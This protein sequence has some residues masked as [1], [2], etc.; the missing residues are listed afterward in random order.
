[1]EIVREELLGSS[2]ETYRLR[3]D[4]VEEAGRVALPPGARAGGPADA[5][6]RLILL[7][8]HRAAACV[9]GLNIYTWA[10]RPTG[11]SGS[12]VVSHPR[13]LCRLPADQSPGADCSAATRS[14]GRG[15]S[16]HAEGVEDSAAA[17]DARQSSATRNEQAAAATPLGLNAGAPEEVAKTAT[18]SDQQIPRGVQSERPTTAAVSLGR[19][20][21]LID[22]EAKI[23]IP[24]QQIT[25]G[26]HAERSEHAAA[27]TSLDRNAGGT[28]EVARTAASSDQQMSGVRAE[29]SAQAA[30]ATSLDR[31]AG[32]AGVVATTETSSDR[33]ATRIQAG[34]SELDASRGPATITPVEDDPR[35]LI[36]C[37]SAGAAYAVLVP[38]APETEGLGTVLPLPGTPPAGSGSTPRRCSVLAARRSGNVVTVALGT[39]QAHVA[40]P[41][42]EENPAAKKRRVAAPAGSAMVAFAFRVDGLDTV[43]TPDAKGATFDCGIPEGRNVTAP[44]E[45]G[46]TPF[47]FDVP[48][49]KNVT[50]AVQ[51]VAA[52]S[53]HSG[54]NDARA[55]I[56]AMRRVVAAGDLLRSNPDG[57]RA[58]CPVAASPS[59]PPA[60]DAAGPNRGHS[61][62]CG[63]AADVVVAAG[64]LSLDSSLP[65]RAAVIRYASHASEV[66][67]VYTLAPTEAVQDAAEEDSSRMDLDDDELPAA[68]RKQRLPAAAAAV[69][70]NREPALQLRR[71]SWH[72]AVGVW[73]P[74]GVVETGSL[75]PVDYNRASGVFAMGFDVDF[76]LCVLRD[77]AGKPSRGNTAG[78]PPPKSDASKDPVGQRQPGDRETS[79]ASDA[80]KD[81]LR[82]RQPG[83]LETSL[84]SDTS[85]G[86]LRQ[87]Q[88]G[89]HD[90]PP[91]SD[92]SKDP[93]GR[94]PGPGHL[95]TPTETAASKFRRAPGDLATPPASDASEGSL[96]RQPGPGD[97]EAPPE[98][99]AS[100]D[101]LRQRTPGDL[102][103]PPES[104]GCAA[105]AHVAHREGMRLL[106]NTRPKMVA[107][108]FSLPL[109]RYTFLVE[110]EQFSVYA[111]ATELSAV[112]NVAT[113]ALPAPIHGLV[114]VESDEASGGPYGCTVYTL[115]ADGVLHCH[116][117]RHPTDPRGV[118]LNSAGSSEAYR[119]ITAVLSSGGE[120]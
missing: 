30:A 103:T 107:T 72:A 18:S 74:L 47:D 85:K 69:V 106:H 39:R 61:I 52:D 70:P 114:A 49:G 66:G 24:N 7:S 78:G 76:A 44:D 37:T 71:H 62:S 28:E 108:V 46:T 109:W 21:G 110:P 95:E 111:R 11:A 33:Q 32:G 63:V 64:C 113:V 77:V 82:Q 57:T 86:S 68:R 120:W 97:L 55:A 96:R 84:A 112:G 92:A 105:L 93:L 14:P 13:L 29:R 56:P 36:A 87:R 89:D 4:F 116:M 34:R 53:L 3:D 101:S 19:N 45:N 119:R 59:K 40:E 94:Q 80:S 65:V 6:G 43:A 8:G 102:D 48:K 41:S 5:E 25:S 118:A 88:P 15:A 16:R 27:D 17:L 104:D 50:P 26:V 20:A 90:T 58:G 31:N 81:S 115:T 79:L 12:P 67:D 99:D 51:I 23:A 22:E 54:P 1:M 10:T 117:V 42:E 2:L 100:K 75:A 73:Q 9:A 35:M 60:A 38:L 98:T 83:D 91:A